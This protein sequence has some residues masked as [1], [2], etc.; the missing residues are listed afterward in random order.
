MRNLIRTYLKGL[1]SLHYI[2]SKAHAR[3]TL[4][5]DDERTKFYETEFE[6][7]L[8]TGS[9]EFEVLPWRKDDEATCQGLRV[10]VR[11]EEERATLAQAF[12]MFADAIEGSMAPAPGWIA[13]QL[14]ENRRLE[15]EQQD[16]AMKEWVR[17]GRKPAL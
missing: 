14:K 16:T 2:T 11:G 17:T 1:E 15:A 12:R 10:C 13:E 7:C 5:D 3:L 4:R 6:I 8:G 9:Y